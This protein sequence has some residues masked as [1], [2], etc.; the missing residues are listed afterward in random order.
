MSIS[1]YALSWKHVTSTFCVLTYTF[2]Q[3]F[4]Y[5]D[6]SLTPSSI[7]LNDKTN[8]RVELV[9]LQPWEDKNL[10]IIIEWCIKFI[11]Q[12]FPCKSH[13]NVCVF[14]H[15]EAKL[16]TCGILVLWDTSNSHKIGKWFYFLFEIKGGKKMCIIL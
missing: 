6:K 14:V 10:N 1:H 15:N 12:L 13:D 2:P 8:F 7:Q 11:I 5:Q 9:T 3:T 16:N 4:I